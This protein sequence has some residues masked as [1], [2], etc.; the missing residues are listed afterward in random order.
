MKTGIIDVGGGLRGIY[1]VGIF[2]YLMDQKI[3][4]DLGI[5]VSAG[6]ANLASFLARQRGRNYVFYTQYSFRRKYMS[7]TNF[8]LHHSFVNLDYVYGTLSNSDGEYPLDYQAIVESPMDFLAVATEA[9]TGKAKYFTKKDFHQ[10]CYDPCKASSA[11]PY[12]C[13]PYPIDGVAYY[14]GAL[15]D[16]V[17]VKKAF[18]MGC[19]KV[20]LLLTRPCDKPREPGSDIKLA[21]KIEKKYPK[22]AENF[23]KRAAVYNA[24]VAL[25]REYE[26]EGKAIIVAPDDTCGVTTLAK[27]KESLDRLYRKGY[28]DAERIKGFLLK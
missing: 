26:K 13:R 19:G 16:P 9:E 8:L 23:R 22:A 2:D 27:D 1:A 24:G 12:V 6:S 28:K 25:A 10:D 18:D 21:Q 14:D 5:G 20:V 7:L 4:F 11:I 3:S 17:P 15:S